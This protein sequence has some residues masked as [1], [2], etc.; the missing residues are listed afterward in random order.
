MYTCACMF[1][2]FAKYSSTIFI[3]ALVFVAVPFLSPSVAVAEE[4]TESDFPEPSTSAETS[5]CI[6]EAQAI[7]DQCMLVVTGVWTTCVATD[8]PDT[9]CDENQR[10]GE[11][12]CQTAKTST[13]ANCGKTSSSSDSDGSGRPAAPTSVEAGFRNILTQGIIF[14]NICTEPANPPLPDSCQC[15]GLGQ[16]SL[17]DILQIVVNVSIFLLGLSGSVALVMFFYGGLLWITAQGKPDRVE[18]GRDTLKHAVIGL[19]IVFG[20]Y[21][22]INFIIAVLTGT[23]PQATIEDTFDQ[24]GAGASSVIDSNVK[25]NN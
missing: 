5:A 11:A 24:T 16:C 18:A 22:F 10:Q 14:A 1:S 13:I 7:Y 3:A 2:R 19:A 25:P 23:S 9:V 6:N 8:T 15:R 17:S 20:S 21:A 12:A 4:P